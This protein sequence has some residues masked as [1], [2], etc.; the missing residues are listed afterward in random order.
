MR[1]WPSRT[2]GP[3]S[4]LELLD[5]NAPT[6]KY[7]LGDIKLEANA[8]Y[9]F[10]MLWRLDGA[11]FVDA[12][13]IWTYYADENRP[14]AQFDLQYALKDIAIGAGTGLRLDFSF[15]VF[16]LDT[17]LKMRDPS[18]PSKNKWVMRNGLTGNDWNVSIGIGYPF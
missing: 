5:P 12:G 10:H 3:G 8:E 14:R 16:R 13:N 6:I 11:F 1:A 7:Y 4:Y 15:F 9:R 2:L 18:L 17:A